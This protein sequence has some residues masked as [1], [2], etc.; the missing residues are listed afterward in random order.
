MSS[1]LYCLACRKGKWKSNLQ[2]NKAGDQKKRI[3][4][5]F[6]VYSIL[7]FHDLSRVLQE[8]VVSLV[9]YCSDYIFQWFILKFRR[10]KGKCD[11]MQSATQPF[12][13]VITQCSSPQTAAYNWTTFLSLCVCGLT[14]KPIMYKKL[15]NTWAPG[16]EVA[17]KLLNFWQLNQSSLNVSASKKKV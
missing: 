16:C 1:S 6:R 2:T 15:D 14:N 11:E 12:Y 7:L 5:S 13:S 17:N 10:K 9:C 3:I 4:R 8:Y